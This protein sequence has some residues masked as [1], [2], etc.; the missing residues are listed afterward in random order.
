MI[1]DRLDNIERYFALNPGFREAAAF[2]RT[3][4]LAQLSAGR[5]EVQGDRMYLMMNRAAGRGKQ[6]AKLEYHRRYI[7]IQLAVSGTDEIGWKA[8]ADCRS[9]EKPFEPEGDF[10]LYQD[11]PDIWVAVPPGHF[12]IFFPEDAHA[13]MGANED[14]VKAVMKVAVDWANP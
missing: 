5:H 3:T 2:L 6:G 8:L 12:A 1:L 7:D 4:D 14:L 9:A 10:G 11:R 13:P